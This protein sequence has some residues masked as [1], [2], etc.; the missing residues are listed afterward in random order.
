MIIT[1]RASQVKQGNLRLFTT[2]LRVRDLR[3]PCFFRIDTLDV[4]EGEGYQRVLN[5]TRAKRLAEYLLDAHEASEAFLPTSLFLA[6]DKDLPFDEASGTLTINT[7]EVGPF[8]V[9][10]GQHRIRGLVLAAERNSDLDEFQVPVNIAVDLDEVTQMCHFL[11]VNTTQKSVDA[12]IEQQIVARLTDM[13][14]FEETPALPRWIKRV[15]ERGEVHRA[16]MI[17]QYLNRSNGSPWKG[18]IQMANAGTA[19]AK[20]ATVK[21]AS[22][23]TSIKKHVL[24]PSN[25]ISGPAWTIDKQQKALLNYWAAISQLLADGDDEVT[26]LFKTNGLHLFHAASPAVFLH[27]ANRQDFKQDTIVKLLRKG[28]GNLQSEFLGMA[29]P[30]FWY[31][32]KTASG[33]NQAALRKYAQALAAA[34]NT[35]TQSGEIQM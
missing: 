13:I 8:N 10:D 19:E 27:L 15:V 7:K 18:K 23:V 33:L 17:V 1:R 28:F 21:Q 31:R 16:L 14:D 4:A 25:P 11:I 35:Q 20:S 26:V 6:T 29:Q 32:G 2:S 5:V 30:Q 24:V 12:A 9:V 22:F 3:V 34:I